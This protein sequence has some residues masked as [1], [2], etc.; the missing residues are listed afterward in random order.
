MFTDFNLLPVCL[1]LG[2]N[3]S[4]LIVPSTSLIEKSNWNFY[5]KGIWE[6]QSPGFQSCDT[7]ENLESGDDT[8]YQKSLR[9]TERK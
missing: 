3:S 2:G 8:E 5:D 6:I 7:R 1:P 9:D 4:S